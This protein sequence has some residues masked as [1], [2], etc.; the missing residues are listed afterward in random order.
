MH[1]YT[2]FEQFLTIK[3]ETFES[4]N[5]KTNHLVFNM[6]EYSKRAGTGYKKISCNLYVN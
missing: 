5:T 1:F 2:L 6:R 3:I 4:S